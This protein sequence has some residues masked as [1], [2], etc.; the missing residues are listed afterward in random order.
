MWCVSVNL[1][2]GRGSRTLMTKQKQCHL[3]SKF[4]LA[5][6]TFIN[7]FVVVY[8]WWLIKACHMLP[9]VVEYT[10]IWLIFL[11]IF[12]YFRAPKWSEVLESWTDEKFQYFKIDFLN[13]VQ[14]LTHVPLKLKS[15]SS[16]FVISRSI[17]PLI[18]SAKWL[19]KI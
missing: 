1:D 10:V 12:G 3:K 17:D 5:N 2:Q 9:A 15:I 11:R 7:V 14:L 6:L 13:K 8:F 19:R 18:R 16:S 4:F